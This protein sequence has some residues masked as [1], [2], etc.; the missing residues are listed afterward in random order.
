M[1]TDWCVC[2]GGKGY[3]LTDVEG[4]PRLTYLHHAADDHGQHVE[5]EAQ[6][7]EECQRHKGLLGV[8]HILL[9]NQHVHG[10]GR[11]SH[12]QVWMGLGKCCQHCQYFGGVR[13]CTCGV[14]VLVVREQIHV[15]SVCMRV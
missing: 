7:V 6:D 13:V 10:E 11:E 14:C 1:E 8:Q 9:V 12:L 4:G 3:G 15:S 2:V 5:G